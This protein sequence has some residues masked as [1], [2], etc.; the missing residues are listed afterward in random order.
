MIHAL[1]KSVFFRNKASPDSDFCWQFVQAYRNEAGQPRQRILASLGFAPLPIDEL[2]PMAKTLERMLLEQ[3]SLFSDE[4]DPIALSDEASYWVDRIYRQIVRNERFCFPHPV[5]QPSSSVDRAA[6][7]LPSEAQ[8][9]FIDQI[10]HTHDA[11]LGPLLVTKAAWEQLQL[12]ACLRELGFSDTQI[13]AAAA[14]VMS[15]LVMYPCTEYALV[16]WIP[17]TALPELLGDSVLRFDHKYFYRI[18]DKLLENKQAIEAHLRGQSKRLFALERTTLLYDLTNTYFEGQALGN[19]KAKRARSKEKRHDRPLVVLGMV[20]DGNGFPLAHQTFAGNTNDGKSLVEMAQALKESVAEEAPPE[21]ALLD[22]GRATAGRALVVIDAGVATAANLRLLREAGFSYL[23]NDSRRQRKGYQPEFADR[24]AFTPLPGRFGQANKLPVEVRLLQELTIEK[25][26]PTEPGEAKGKP[27]SDDQLEPELEQSLDTILLCRSHGRQSKERAMFS[28][29]EKRFMEAAAKLDQRLKT[30]Q[31]KDAK[32]I[33]EAIGRLKA[34]H[35]RVQR[36][37]EINLKEANNP[38][39]GLN[40]QRNDTEH[41]Q[42]CDLFG[43]YALRT[44]RQD[45]ICAELWRSYMSL[46]QAEE[47]FRAMKTDLGLRP[48]Y[49]HKEHRVDG[50]IFITVLALHLWKW[51]RQ[52][53]DECGESRDWTTVRCLLETHCYSTLLVPAE[54]GS[55]YH[56]R[57]A[58]RPEVRQREIYEKLGIK[59]AGLPKSKLKMNRS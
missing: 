48:N 11:L 44:D 7:A 35:P 8:R 19:P 47:G 29:A 17:T 49:H 4:L 12:S 20:Y 13:T 31:L 51:I 15:R 10:E 28:K 59:T 30:G 46:T 43:C 2:K 50:H 53:F 40:W 37:Y 5:S 57:K 6:R 56:L 54:A 1:A 52:K 38:A 39:A 18:S 25:K 58:G 32:K 16:R 45:H 21:Q 34:Q 3:G 41:E 23:V 26:K 24:E 42:H 22:E 33:Q 9:V 14:S 27:D 36:L 55:L